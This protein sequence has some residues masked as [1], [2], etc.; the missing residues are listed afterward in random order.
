MRILNY[1]L[2]TY[3]GFIHISGSD[4]KIYLKYIRHGFLKIFQIYQVRIP[5]RELPLLLVEFAAGERLEGGKWSPGIQRTGEHAR[6]KQIKRS[7]R[8]G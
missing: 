8:K 7:L 6:V 2:T 4:S 3:I 1:V 5:K